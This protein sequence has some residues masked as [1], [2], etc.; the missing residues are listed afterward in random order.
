MNPRSPPARPHIGINLASF[1]ATDWAE[2]DA[3]DSTSDSESPRQSALHS[4]WGGG[5]RNVPLAAP[6]L[7]ARKSS[8]SSSSTLAFSYTHLQAPNPGSYPPR[9][10]VADSNS[11]KNGWTIVRT[12]RSRATSDSQPV[13]GSGGKELAGE[14]DV[15]AGDIDVEGDMILGDLEAELTVDA[16]V[17]TVQPASP[18]RFDA[19]ASSIRSDADDIVTGG[20]SS[21]PV[22]KLLSDN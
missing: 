18:S 17:T 20:Y 3:W 11:P 6:K 8:N 2:D 13:Q 14:P 10:E 19:C 5:R 7:V 16:R 4:P 15:N 12:A 21:H 22:F 1:Q 9:A